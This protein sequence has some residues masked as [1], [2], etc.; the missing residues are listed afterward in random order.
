MSPPRWRKLHPA[1][2]GGR[3]KRLFL[4]SLCGLAG[5]MKGRRN[6]EA[7]Q[8]DMPVR[9]AAR[10]PVP[11]PMPPEG[12]NRPPRV[13]LHPPSGNPRLQHAT[14]SDSQT[15]GRGAAHL[16]QQDPQTGV[17]AG[18]GKWGGAD[19]PATAKPNRTEPLQAHEYQQAA[20]QL[21][22]QALGD[23][24]ED[25]SDLEHLTR[26]TE[27]IHGTRLDLK[28]GR[29]NIAADVDASNGASA[30][31]TLVS[32]RVGDT[33]GKNARAGVALAYGAGNCDQNGLINT[34]RYAAT[35]RGEG[36][37]VSTVLSLDVAHSWSQ[38]NR[39]DKTLSGGT[40]EP[41]PAI[42]LDSWAN[43][44]A[45]RL[46][47]SAWASSADAARVT[48]TLDRARG[49]VNLEAM[50]SARDA[51]LPGGKWHALA[52]RTLQHHTQKA[53]RFTREF[54]SN[55]VV[56]VGFSTEARHALTA[57]PAL[58]QQLMAVAAGRSA[59]DLNV[60]EAAKSS[61]SFTIACA[62]MNLDAS[63]RPPIVIPED[64][65]NE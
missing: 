61:T 18:T 37:T 8:T 27:T 5:L 49:A 11:P 32:Y 23:P 43:G 47:D 13:A 40:T 48:E 4:P 65:V 57:Q 44:P 38:L 62:A 9:M 10:A 63:S 46:R 28:H 22:A 41:K 34:R 24:I 30:A 29:G 39:P 19:L 21:A 6:P 14:E 25:R 7:V 60:R 50:N 17:F 1:P 16:G 31:R 12:F 26:A 45:V 64:R 59:Y 36:E 54:A 56:G 15:Q 35:L 51:A 58:T 53:T 42:V 3:E 2:G 52:E 33:H 55:S 20:Y